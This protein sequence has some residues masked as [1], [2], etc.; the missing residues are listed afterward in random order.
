MEPVK[1]DGEETKEDEKVEKTAEE[2]AADQKKSE[3]E[4]IQK[5]D[6]FEKEK[7][8]VPSG[9]YN[10]AVRKQRELEL[11]KREL[12]KKLQERGSE[13]KPVKK[14]VIKDE[15]EED[16]DDDEGDDKKKPVKKEIDLEAIEPISKEVKELRERIDQRDADDKKKQRTAFFKAHPEYLTDSEKWQELLDEMDNSLNPHSKDNYYKQLTKAHRLISGDSDKYKDESDIE[17]KKREMASEA[18]RD[19]GALKAPGNNKTALDER[20]LRLAKK[21]PRGFEF[22]PKE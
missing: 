16:E 15:E 18:G 17:R 14:V 21:M 5:K 22:K 9:K 3:E 4:A 12:E 7:D 10:E 13:I 1:K 20:S 19:N 8:V 2:L 11:E 6:E